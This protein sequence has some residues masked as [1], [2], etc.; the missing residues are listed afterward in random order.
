[1]PWLVSKDVIRLSRG[2]RRRLV[3]L[4]RR[5]TAPWQQVQRAKIIL[6]A[7]RKVPNAQI[8]RQVGCGVDTVRAARRRYLSDGM[9]GMRDRP[10]SG[11]PLTYDIDVRLQI[12]AIATS[13]PPEPDSQWTHRTIAEHLADEDGNGI[14]PSQIGRILAE[15]DLKPHKVRGWLNR[16]DDQQ[17]FTRAAA[18]CDLYRNPPANTV[19]LSID[20][21]TAIQAKHRKRPTRPAGR[22]RP[23]RRE[24]EYVRHGTVSL[25]AALNVVNGFVHPK[26][27]TKNNSVTFIDFLT[28]LDQLIDTDKNIHLIMDNGSSHTSKA[29]RAW[30][31]AHPRIT[32]TYTPKHASWLNIVE[33]FFSIL[34]RRVLLR[35]EFTSRDQLA[36]RILTFITH[37]D[38]TAKPFRWTYDG[39]PLTAA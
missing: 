39:R 2:R 10:R 18:I 30:L 38:R 27:I 11:R 16:P 20:E 36:K 4:S 15:A 7:A 22:G 31:T 12:V 23:V 21:K 13:T 19:L 5:S 28:E 1:M 37:Y 3:R 9:R 35:G 29:T 6:L 34:T 25:I 8:A 17:F 14:S 24:F 26:I 33:I 32:V